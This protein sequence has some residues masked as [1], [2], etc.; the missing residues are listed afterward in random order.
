MDNY[1]RNLKI[2]YNSADIAIGMGTAAP[3]GTITSMH[4]VIQTILANSTFK[5]ELPT[6]FTGKPD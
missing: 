1:C 4:T 3:I 5:L 6:E 2:V